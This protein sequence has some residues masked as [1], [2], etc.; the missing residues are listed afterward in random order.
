[1]RLT[2]VRYWERT[3]ERRQHTRSQLAVDGTR[4]YM[5]RLILHRLD[6]VGLER[7]RI[8]EIGAGD[9]AWLPFLAKK[10]PSSEIAGIDYSESGCTLLT[11]RAREAGARIEVVHEDMFVEHCRLHGAFDVVFSIGV[12]E[13]FDDLGEVLRAAKRFLKRDGVMFTLIPNMAGVLGTLARKWNRA[14][15]ETHNPYDLSSFVLGHRDAQL[16]IDSANYLGSTNFSVL[17]AC[18]PE[19]RG[20]SWQ[21]ARVLM[22][23]S[24]ATWWMEERVGEFPLSKTFSPYIYSISR[25][26]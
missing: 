25:T 2:N 4:N 7:K 11:E 13:H 19:E 9:S 12:V 5:N 20:I 3:Y 22:A 26:Q 21:M 6:G 15:Y 16:T 14:V 17:S 10:Y 24:R 1:M 8:L 23:M 18:F